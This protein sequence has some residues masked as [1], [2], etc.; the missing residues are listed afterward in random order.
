[1]RM[2]LINV[3]KQLSNENA[4]HTRV[5]SERTTRAV[6]YHDIDY[7]ILDTRGVLA[8]NGAHRPLL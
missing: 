5:D 6:G 7:F 2:R 1:M 8:H 4:P 3:A